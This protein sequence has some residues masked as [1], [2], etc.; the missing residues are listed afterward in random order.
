MVNQTSV[1]YIEACLAFEM[2]SFKGKDESVVC[3][4]ALLVKPQLFDGVEPED[5]WKVFFYPSGQ[6]P[7]V[8]GCFSFKRHAHTPHSI[9]APLKKK[10]KE[11]VRFIFT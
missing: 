9:Q 2:N 6:I 8:S 10:L 3:F 7:F 1:D 11:T 4:F 5:Q